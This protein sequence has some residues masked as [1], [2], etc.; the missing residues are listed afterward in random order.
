MV[1]WMLKKDNDTR[2]S[3]EIQSLYEMNTHP[4]QSISI[5]NK[6]QSNIAWSAIDFFNL[7]KDQITHDELIKT[8]NSVMMLYP[9]DD[10]IK[11]SAHY[12][13]YNRMFNYYQAPLNEGDQLNVE[14]LKLITLGSKDF[15]T[16][17]SDENWIFMTGSLS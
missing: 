13:K 2:L 10:E 5:I 17:S 7:E 16:P 11:N 1:L 8:L 12:L 4:N 6:I 3:N 14:S 9:N 15:E